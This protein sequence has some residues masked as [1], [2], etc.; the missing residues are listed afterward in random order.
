MLECPVAQKRQ[1]PQTGRNEVTTWS[2]CLTPRD[3]R[4]AL[5]DDAGALVAADDREARHDVPVAKMLVG[6]AQA[7]GD[8]AD[9]HLPLLGLVEIQL[10][11]LP[12]ATGVPQRSCPGLHV[13]LSSCDADVAIVSVQSFPARCNAAADYTAPQVERRDGSAG[14]RRHERAPGEARAP[15]EGRFGR[16]LTITTVWR[17]DPC[18]A[19]LRVPLLELDPE[20]GAQLDPER[21][22]QARALLC[23]PVV[24]LD[25]DRLESSAGPGLLIVRGVLARQIVSGGA[26][27]ATELLGPGDVLWPRTEADADLLALEV[28]WEPLSRVLA[29][30]LDERICHVLARWPELTAV[31]L[32]RAG[33]RAHRLAVTQAI[34]QLTG[35]ERR[36][37]AL[38]W[39]LAGRFGRVTPDGVVV[40]LAL[41]HQRLGELIGA[42]RPTVSTALGVLARE[43]S[44][45]RREDGAWLLTGEPRSAVGG[46]GLGEARVGRRGAPVAVQDRR[47]PD[48][49]RSAGRRAGTAAAGARADCGG[50][51]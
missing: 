13:V 22:V 24:A 37:H 5:L 25:G 34:A 42:R 31:L 12:V 49:G 15:G 39:H 41:S 11:D 29:A 30:V 36:L 44:L 46:R 20:L 43:G 38:L 27:S 3:A 18:S 35:V 16:L 47:V 6:V 48:L 17:D 1:W 10:H 50:R 40:P 51:R 32:D 4:P 7:R 26:V 45:R 2:P 14:R 8:P 33:A 19:P 21:F 28:R 9:Q 23:A